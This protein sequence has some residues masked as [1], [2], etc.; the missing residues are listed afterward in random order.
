MD[1]KSFEI[2]A[3]A[4]DLRRAL[5]SV[6]YSDFSNPNFKTFFK[7]AN[8]FFQKEKFLL[9]DKAARKRLSQAKKKFQK[10][11][12]YFKKNHHSYNQYALEDLLTTSLFLQ[13]LGTL[14]P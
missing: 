11:N 12:Q 13:H 14:A 9:K 3:I 7:R 10:V 6:A 1:D 5:Y 2:L 4:S 8:N